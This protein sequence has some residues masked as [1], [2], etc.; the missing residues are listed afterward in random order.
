MTRVRKKKCVLKD[1]FESKALMKVDRL[2]GGCSDSPCFDPLHCR[3][4]HETSDSEI[5]RVYQ[6]S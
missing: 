3:E 5:I 1:F 2:C 6:V 4:R